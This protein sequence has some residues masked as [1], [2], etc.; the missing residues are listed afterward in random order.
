MSGGLSS[1]TKALIDTGSPRTIFPRGIGDL[2]GFEFPTFGADAP[3]KIK[4]L[5]HEWPAIT[6]VVQLV[7][8]PFQD[9]AWD[10][11]VDF[12]LEEGLPFGVLGYE[13]FLNRWAVSFVGAFGYFVVEPADD[14]DARVPNE[15]FDR[16]KRD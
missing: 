2:L 13:G 6:E 4:L 10:A 3:T 16:L 5:G 7:L 12:V 9:D 14:F 15:L 11:E 8:R 1:R